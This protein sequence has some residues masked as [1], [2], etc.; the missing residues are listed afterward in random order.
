MWD[1][2]LLGLVAL[3]TRACLGSLSLSLMFQL[4]FF[5]SCHPTIVCIVAPIGAR[6][7]RVGYALPWQ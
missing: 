1:V 4:Y 6:V 3:A 7:R 5:V 2:L